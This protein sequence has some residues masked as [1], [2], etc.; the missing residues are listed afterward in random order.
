SS[1]ASRGVGFV[2]K[3]QVLA[4]GE[5]ALGTMTPI[6]KLLPGTPIGSGGRLRPAK[7]R[8]WLS[9]IHLED[10]V[11]ILL[12]ALDHPEAQGPINGTAPNPVRNAMFAKTLSETLWKP[13]TPW[14]FYI[15]I[16]LPDFLLGVLLGE[17]ATLI[18]TGQRVLPTKVQTLGYH[19]RFPFLS[20]ALRDL[21]AQGSA[22]TAPPERQPA[23]AGTSL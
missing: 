10:I 11:G 21:F 2:Y 4:R 1:C 13:Y 17:V 12:L 9:W 23:A 8:Q 19:F 5:G 16:G 3:S 18:T 15:P 7:G 20:G 22:R 14:R 6:F